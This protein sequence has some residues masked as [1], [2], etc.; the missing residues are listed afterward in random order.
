[1]RELLYWSGRLLMSYVMMLCWFLAFVPVP[2]PMFCS[3]AWPEPDWTHQTAVRLFDQNWVSP[4]RA[5]RNAT[6]CNAR[7]DKVEKGK[8]KRK[9]L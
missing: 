4:V 1:M 3:C 9:E 7:Q 6:Q 5:N 2:H 8:G